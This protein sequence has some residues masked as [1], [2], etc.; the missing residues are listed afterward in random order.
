[1]VD[2]AKL[3]I[4]VDSTSVRKATTDVNALGASGKK[5]QEQLTKSTDKATGSFQRMQS[6]ASILKGTI[7]ALGVG[8][9]AR[10]VVQYSD[11]WTAANNQLRLVTQGTKDLEVTQK[12]LLSVANDSR[13]SFDASATLYTRLKRSTLDLNLSQGELLQLTGDINKSFISNGASAEEASGAIRQLSQGLAS[14]VLRGDEFNSVAEQAPAIMDAI[15]AATN[16]TRGELRDFAADGGITAE[17]VVRSLR[18]ASDAINDDF[19]KSIATLGQSF[20]V[21]NNNMMEFI[22]SSDLV[23][24]TMKGA[25]DTVI[26]LSENLDEFGDVIAAVSIIIAARMVPS[27]IASGKAMQVATAE[28]IRYQA[29][30]ATMAGVSGRAAVAQTALG[31]ATAGFKGA[32]ALLGGP[33]G[34]TITLLGGLALAYKQVTDAQNEAKAAS[35]DYIEKTMGTEGLSLAI[36]GTAMEINKLSAQLIQIKKNVDTGAIGMDVY[37]AKLDEQQDLF[38]RLN[39]LSERHAASQEE[40]AKQGKKVEEQTDL[41]TAATEE[42]EAARKKLLVTIAKNHK[43]DRELIRGLEDEIRMLDMGERALAVFEAGQKLSANATDET[44]ERVEELTAALFDKQ[45]QMEADETAEAAAEATADLIAELEAETEALGETEIAQFRLNLETKIGSDF[46]EEQA[47][48]I[49]E[50]IDKLVAKK[51]EVDAL[52][53]AEAEALKEYKKNERAREKAAKDAAKEIKKQYIRTHEFIS[54]SLLDFSE[55][56]EDAFDALAKSFEKTVKKMVADWLASGLMNIFGMGGGAP[57]SGTG[58]GSLFGVGGGT[59]GGGGIGS[60]LGGASGASSLLGGT[61]LLGNGGFLQGMLGGSSTFVGPPTAAGAAGSGLISSMGAFMTSPA[62][63]AAGVLIAG[64][65]IHNKTSDPDNF[66]RRMGGF[67]SAPTAGAQDTFGVNAF[68]SG[69]KPTGIAHGGSI[70]NAM[71]NID[72]FR[73]IDQLVTDATKAAGGNI[74]LSGATL[75]GFGVDGL[76]GSSGTFFGKTGRTGESDFNT[77]I[78]SFSAQLARHIEGLAPETLAQLVGASSTEELLLILEGVRVTNEE[79]TQQSE[80]LSQQTI[81]LIESEAAVVDAN[82][83]LVDSNGTVVATMAELISV[84]SQLPLAIQQVMLGQMNAAKASSSGSTS[85]FS[86]PAAWG[87][88]DPLSAALQREK[89]VANNLDKAAYGYNPSTGQWDNSKGGFAAYWNR[90]KDFATNDTTSPLSFSNGVLSTGGGLNTMPTMGPNLP[91]VGPAA[92]VVGPTQPTGDSLGN[93][94][95]V[96]QVM[97]NILSQ[98]I[99][100]SQIQDRWDLNGMPDTRTAP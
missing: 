87:T 56:G 82:G 27:I 38:A 93:G 16:K 20:E 60:L 53:A 39:T 4:E 23:E 33:I 97:V 34:V 99:D 10:K 78:N 69:F 40:D 89:R 24:T 72:Q 49:Q 50:A 83:D 64:K 35:I 9:A 21:A 13:S 77:Q 92:P 1:M 5:N 42:Y 85:A 26:F 41:T 98:L 29:A 100:Q 28:S 90:N 12:A 58:I 45:A 66:T 14:G 25:G 81:E 79:A 88:I 94:D 47:A 31:T 44:R 6:Q 80:T 96:V 15:A 63:I 71:A 67:L 36:Q 52:A 37:N 48:S 18:E 61:G 2:F 86:A 76:A 74:N 68:A 70:A 17:L 65:L 59:G 19:D 7:A 75:G 32:L 22:G 84:Q 54:E 46:N 30:L 62:G 8:L 11:A 95:P 73:F 51:V 43:A 91:P 55:D 3:K 57:A